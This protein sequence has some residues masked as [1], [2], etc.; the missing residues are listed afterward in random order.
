MITVYITCSD[1]KEAKRI[2]LHLLE[3]KMVACANLFPITS[4]YWWKNKI[5][6]SGETVILAKAPER[7]FKEIEKEVKKLHSYKVPCICAWKAAHVNKDYSDWVENET[8]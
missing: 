4:F 6:Q 5:Q 2:S 1:H 3:K 7:N 8:A